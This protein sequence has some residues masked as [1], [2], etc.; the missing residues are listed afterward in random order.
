MPGY[1]ARVYVPE[2]GQEPPVVHVGGQ[3]RAEGH[4]PV[5]P[6]QVRAGQLIG[7]DY[8]LTGLHLYNFE[9]RRMYVHAY[10]ER[11]EKGIFSLA[12]KT[13]PK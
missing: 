4:A 5:R 8:A 1:P 6:S 3:R 2:P 7:T 11:E 9:N 13:P 10:G 12:S